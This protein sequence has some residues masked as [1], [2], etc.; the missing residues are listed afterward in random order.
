[1]KNSILP[2]FLLA[3]VLTLPAAHGSLDRLNDSPRHQEWVNIP[4]N[5]RILKAFLVYPEVNRP[6]AAVIIIHEN[7]G[8]T[9][10]VRTVADR[11]AEAG[12][13]AIAPDLLS[14]KGPNG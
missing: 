2:V 12:Y 5:G 1:M 14:G 3:A 9:D 8:L 6:V 13:L 11:L 10:W 4:S 7:R